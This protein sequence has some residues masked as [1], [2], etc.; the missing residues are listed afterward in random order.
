MNS[1]SKTAVKGI[2]ENII[3]ITSLCKEYGESGVV[4]FPSILPKRNTRLSKLIRQVND[5]LHDLCKMNNIYFWS[6]DNISRNVICDDGV[7]LNQK[8]YP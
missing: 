4:V 3:K 7:H 1:G 5:I 2:A 6:N 8:S